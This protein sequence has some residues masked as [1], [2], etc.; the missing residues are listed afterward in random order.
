[1]QA[2]YLETPQ[3][4]ASMM[5]S[6]ALKPPV[7]ANVAIVEFSDLEC[8]A[9]AAANPT[10]VEAAAKYHVPLVRR[11]LLIPGHV[12]SPTAAVNARWFDSKSKELG[13]QYRATIFASQQS[14]AT[15]DDLNQA[16]QKFAEQH[17]VA[18]PFVVDPGGKIADAISQ[19]RGLSRDLNISRTPTFFVVTAHSHDP[20]HSFVQFTDPKMLY[21]Y[22]DQAVS[23]T[24]SKAKAPAAG[25]KAAHS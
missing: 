2:Q 1:M 15:I 16:T 4:P 24:S 23:A 3:V 25:R 9:C 21:V 11:D 6:A 12:W 10:V 22:L 20:G 17:H 13:E 8:P 14:I 5:E 7:G 18:L 19:D